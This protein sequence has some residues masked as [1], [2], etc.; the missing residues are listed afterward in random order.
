MR[1]I[2]LHTFR[3]YFHPFS[4]VK[5]NYFATTI[6]RIFPLSL[7]C[8]PSLL[9]V[10]RTKN[11]LSLLAEGC[12]LFWRLCAA[13][14]RRSRAFFAFG[15]LESDDIADFKI[16]ECYALKLLGMEEE[17]LR[18]AIARDETEST[19]RKGLDSTLHD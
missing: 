9:P 19:I 13:D 18:F 14:V 12:F 16:I 17:V 10:A 3:I 15:D 1:D 5:Q 7:K 8:K 11:T 6:K 2:P 4:F